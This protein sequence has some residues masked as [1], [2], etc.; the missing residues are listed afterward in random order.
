MQTVQ[1]FTDKDK[2]MLKQPLPDNPCLRPICHGLASSCC[3]CENYYKYHKT[4]KLYEDLGL[5]KI[6]SYYKRVTNILKEIKR[7]E[8]ELK[9]LTKELPDFL[10]EKVKEMQE[11]E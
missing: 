6:A 3:G 9:S 8:K 2:E 11:E 5:L 4:I 1:I 7:Y 10:Q